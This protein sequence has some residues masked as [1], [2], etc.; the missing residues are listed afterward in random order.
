MADEQPAAEAEEAEDPVANFVLVVDPA[1]APADE[2]E[3]PPPYAVVG[4]WLFDEEGN[5]QRFV[6]NPDYVPSR[7]GSPTDPVDAAMQTVVQNGA[8]GSDLLEVMRDAEFGVAINADG[9]A[10]IAPSPDDIQCVLVTTAE[11]HR[12][13][14]EVD[15]WVELHALELAAALPDSGVD[16][17]LNPGAPASMR[18]DAPIFKNAM[19]AG[20]DLDEE[21]EE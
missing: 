20:V 8:D 6:A 10:V 16:V 11:S 4:G 9:S 14:V 5:T 7:P 13:R 21:A 15:G 3:E 12:K 2:E 1:W 18:L 17:L 19:L